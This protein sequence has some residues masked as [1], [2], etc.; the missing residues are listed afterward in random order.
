MSHSTKTVLSLVAAAILAATGSACAKAQAKTTPEM[1][2]L[3]V[4]A[5]PPRNVEP[6]LSALP[7]LVGPIEEPARS[8]PTGTRVAP[9][10]QQRGEPARAEPP[11]S[12]VPSDA[13]KPADVPSRAQSPTILQ[14]IPTGKEGEVE[15]SIRTQL[16]RAVG[17][18]SRVDARLLSADGKANYDQAR[19]FVSQAEEA[20][21]ARN[22]VFAATVAEKAV[23][24][25]AQLAGR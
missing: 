13:T 15:R 5:P 9:A 16:G 14:T 22:L 8:T 18:L 4:P 17:D 24:L 7:P 3:D 10:S 1:P 25:A 21:Q 23:E 20:L 2:S 11:K 6:V 19:R 12:E